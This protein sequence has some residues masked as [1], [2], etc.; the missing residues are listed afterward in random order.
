MGVCAAVYMVDGSVIDDISAL[1]APGSWAI[2]EL[3]VIGPREL[4]LWSRLAPNKF[5]SLSAVVSLSGDKSENGKSRE[6]KSV[7][8]SSSDSLDGS[9]VVAAERTTIKVARKYIMESEWI[10]FE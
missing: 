10:R 3:K 9:T 8:P 5:G 6:D 7:G 1:F 4:R 2:W